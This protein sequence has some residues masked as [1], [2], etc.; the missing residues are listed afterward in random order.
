[1][2]R[3]EIP[4]IPFS[5]KRVGWFMVEALLFIVVIFVVYGFLFIF[6][7]LL[8][9]SLFGFGV[10]ENGTGVSSFMLLS[11]AVLAVGSVIG[12][13]VVHKLSHKVFPLSASCIGLSLKG[14]GRELWAGTSVAVGLYAVGFLLT[15]LLNGASIVGVH[16]RGAVLLQT[17]IFFFFV[18]AFEETMCRGFLL[19]R[20]MDAGVNKFLALVISSAVFSLMHLAN[21]NFAVLPFINLLLA[22]ILLGS[23]YI[24][25]RN[26]WFAIMLHWFWNWLQGP[27]LGFEVSGNEFGES[28]LILET[29]DNVLL[30]GGPFGFEGSL[31]CTLL[32]LVSIF[33]IIRYYERIN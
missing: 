33:L 14:H 6:A 19:G 22:G 13:L 25:T 15:L 24:Y 17:W 2:N 1:M 29:T 3:S 18:A 20:M 8:R 21:P 30:N 26:L 9:M 16:F 4:S 32:M 10:N 11:E 27:V 23:A 5:W 28:L 31:M 12:L 7:G